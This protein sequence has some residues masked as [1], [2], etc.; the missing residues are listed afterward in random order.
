[1][2]SRADAVAWGVAAVLVLAALGLTAQRV[3][4]SPRGIVLLTDPGA[5]W[6]MVDDPV[7]AYP[8]QW[9]REQPA[10][11]RFL[12]AFDVGD[13][14]AP[15][16]LSLRAFGEPRVSVNGVAVPLRGEEK[17]WKRPREAE[18][19]NLLRRGSNRIEVEVRNARGPGLLA[20]R[21]D[22]SAGVL[23]STAESE[24]TGALEDGVVRQ[25]IA[26][27]ERRHPSSLASERPFRELAR[28]SGVAV[29]AAGVSALV[30]L[31]L[32]ARLGPAGLA[33]IPAAALVGIGCAWA[34]LFASKLAGLDL[35]VG[36]D[37]WGGHLDYL[38]LLRATGRVPVATDHWATYHP[39]LFYGLTLAIDWIAVG[40]GAARNHPLA[41]KAI[42]L[43]AGF[44][45]VWLAARL[46]RR[47][48]PA[49][50]GARASAALFAGFLPVNLYIAAYFSNEGL[51]AFLAGAAFVLAAEILLG[52]GVP[53][54]RAALL[55]L[56]LGLALLTKFTALLVAGPA[57]LAVGIKA[58]WEWRGRPLAIARAIATLVVPLLAVAGWFYARNFVLY[59]RPLIGN[60][61][62]PGAER[63][64]WSPPGFHTPGYYLQF[65]EVL[66]HPYF[67]GFVSFWDSL[68]ST[69]WGDGLLAGVAALKFRHEVW[70]YGFMAAGYV[71]A[72]PLTALLVA[73]FGVALRAAWRDPDPGRRAALGLL[74]VTPSA[75]GF[76]LFF[77]T[78]GLPYHGWARAP[79]LLA[80][81]PALALFFALGLRTLDR[82][83]AERGWTPA[84]A[85]V[86]G[87]LGATACVLYLGF[88]A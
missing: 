87:W 6:I 72:L 32:R 12:A 45:Q 64:W 29:L 40:F 47:L 53:L 10:A 62:L 7:D 79:Y 63:V 13:P 21:L 27:S 52:K 25:T 16:R 5:P 30:F 46:A 70:N 22:G 42:P 4:S 83:L 23:L 49:D 80:A 36:F 73:G 57:L 88:A 59:G 43:L 51:H 71:L 26:A 35:R 37:A 82:A 76:A 55:S 77:A 3:L 75:M 17:N 81:T 58:A 54:G 69:F 68:Y 41:L 28:S 18:I 24:W 38:Q 15:A 2:K 33:R 44:G 66:V 20:L 84:R 85:G 19:S 74:L 39:P 14:S 11:T 31:L 8:R 9:G 50:P 78:L 1:M 86:F 61:D 60:W 34:W 48:L 67:S 56:L 65:G